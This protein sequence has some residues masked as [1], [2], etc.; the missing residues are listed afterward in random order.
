M[1]RQ[2]RR[3]VLDRLR[4]KRADAEREILSQTHEGG[5]TT[6]VELIARA[7]GDDQ[8]NVAFGALG[9][10]ARDLDVLAQA[11]DCGAHGGNELTS[12]VLY[13]H[14]SYLA[15]RARAVVTIAARIHEAQQAKG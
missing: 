6:L 8:E 1:G 9:A 4:H 13:E 7:V 3:F 5:R 14:V 12:E 2:R 11:I 15:V 10:L